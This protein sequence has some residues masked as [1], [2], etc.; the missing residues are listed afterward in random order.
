MENISNLSSNLPLT[1][2]VNDQTIEDI[3]KELNKE[4]RDAA[5]AVASLYKLSLQKKTIIRHQG[6]LDCINDLLNV[7][8]N[9]GDIENWAL[10]K[11]LELNNDHESEIQ[12]NNQDPNQ[13]HG[14]K[15]VVTN[16]QQNHLDISQ[17]GQFNISVP[18]PHKFPPS[19]SLLSVDYSGN[20]LH[21]IQR[22]S[23][24]FVNNQRLEPSSNYQIDESK[25]INNIYE[26][27]IITDHST[28]KRNLEDEFIDKRSKLD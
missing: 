17:H 16:E 24:S 14:S 23:H 4:F 7:L 5:N 11:K 12:K 22:Q 13:I 20:K 19:K 27:Q 26:N 3:D 18:T 8:K 10:M 2:S 6:Y 21:Q 9:D 28:I 1:K 15:H 25:N